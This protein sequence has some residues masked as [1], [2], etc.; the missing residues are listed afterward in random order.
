LPPRQRAPD[1][2]LVPDPFHD[3]ALPS[4]F[5]RL[6]ISSPRDANAVLC[7]HSSASARLVVSRRPRVIRTGAESAP[8]CPP[9]EWSC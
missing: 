3:T 2:V 1:A 4:L 8:C 7:R 5:H 9:R 6:L